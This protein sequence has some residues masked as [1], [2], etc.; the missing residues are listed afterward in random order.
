ML[1]NHE[2]AGDL[3]NDIAVGALLLSCSSHSSLLPLVLVR[4][5]EYLPCFYSRDN[6]AS[7]EAELR[8]FSGSR[9][10]QFRQLITAACGAGDHA[11]LR[12]IFDFG[13]C[14]GGWH[15]ASLRSTRRRIDTPLSLR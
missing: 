1:S 14:A 15:I 3:S 4:V 2:R 8:K 5:C 7:I 11:L 9:E 6:M 10:E 13:T 12:N